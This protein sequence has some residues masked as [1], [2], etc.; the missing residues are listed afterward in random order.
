MKKSGLF[1]N[2]Y[3]FLIFSLG[4]LFLAGCNKEDSNDVNQDKIWTKYSLYYNKN[5]DVTHAVAQFRFGGPTGTLLELKD[6]SGAKVTFNGATMPYSVIWSGHE[7]DFPG[8][9]T[10]GTFKYTNTDGMVYTNSL[11]SGVA[12]SASFPANF[13]TI[14]KS[15]ANT[16]SWVG[17]PLAPHESLG[18]YVGTWTWGK[19]ALFFTNGD[20]ATSLVMGVN[21]KSNLQLGQA[22]VYLNRTYTNTTINGTEKGGSINYTF[23]PLNK[24]VQVIP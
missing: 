19:D 4:I 14:V 11:P 24:T 10:T 13:D 15:S 6:S 2:Y 3:F 17:N 18:F 23:Q 8:N 20:N 12:D 9:V 5:D 1:S 16:F 22:T 21:A 7:L